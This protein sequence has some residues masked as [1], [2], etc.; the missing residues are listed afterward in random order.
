MARK[1]RMKYELR[2]KALDDWLMQKKIKEAEEMAH[3]RELEHR[4]EYERELVN[5]R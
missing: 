3:M 2:C 1:E 4:E 5:E